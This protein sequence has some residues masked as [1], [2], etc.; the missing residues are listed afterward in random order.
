M[1]SFVSSP[2]RTRRL[3]HGLTVG[4]LAICGLA[5]AATPAPTSSATT[6]RVMQWNIH[7]TK[8]SNLVCDPDFTVNTIVAQN[9]DVMSLNESK[10]TRQES[11]ISVN[12]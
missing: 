7:K 3:L 10:R 2:T 6:L 12:H 9:P 4:V 11:E 8:N 5:A 1:A